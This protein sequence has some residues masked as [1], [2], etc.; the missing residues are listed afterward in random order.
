[1][2]AMQVVWGSYSFTAGAC[3]FGVKQRAVLDGRNI[4]YAYDF[5]IDVTGR[6]Y[7]A[8]DSAL[9]T[10]EAALRTALAR[11]FQ[12]FG[13]LKTDGSRSASYWLNSDTI[14]GNVVADGPS[15]TGTAATEYA[16]FRE[17]SFVVR[18]RVPIANAAG[19]VLEFSESV[20]Y[21][22][23]EPEYRMKRA[24]NARPQ[25]QLVW[26]A[27]EYTV[28]QRGR[29]V[30]FL[31]Y[32]APGRQLFPRDRMQAPKITRDNPKRMG[33]DYTEYPI[34]W[35]YVFASANPLVALPNVWTG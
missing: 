22:G 29:A 32:P 4:P 7:G 5:D 27:T 28:T 15:F 3:R 24:I 18:N 8:G 19:A 6:L 34:S 10:A 13:V 12:N 11:P 1:M 16:L 33:N 30:G 35:Q 17:F 2:P 31:D 9:S 23:G 20:E 21:D 26:F 14:G 25:K